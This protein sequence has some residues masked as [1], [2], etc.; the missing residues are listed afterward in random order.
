MGLGLGLGLEQLFERRSG[1]RT[2]VDGSCDFEKV[3]PDIRVRVR[4]RGY[5]LGVVML[6]IAV[7]VMGLSGFRVMESWV[8]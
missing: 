8:D 3:P 1:D 6:G 2:R 7:R 4:V 5:P